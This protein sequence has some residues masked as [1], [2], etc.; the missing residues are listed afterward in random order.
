MFY[1]IIALLN[2]FSFQNWVMRLLS[3]TT[4]DPFTCI[5][6]S[7]LQRLIWPSPAPAGHIGTCQHPP[8]WPGRTDLGPSHVVRLW[9]RLR[10]A[11]W[12]NLTHRWAGHYHPLSRYW[13]AQCWSTLV[14]EKK[15]RAMRYYS[16]SY[17]YYCDYYY[18]YVFIT[19]NGHLRPCF[20]LPPV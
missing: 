19:F 17:S 5:E 20:T 14:Q 10:L 2:N 8:C 18:Y 15:K 16:Y 11:T 13:A 1:L 3:R 6:P 12:D 9:T 7:A 4:R